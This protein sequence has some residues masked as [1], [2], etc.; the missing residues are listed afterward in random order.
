MYLYFQGVIFLHFCCWA[1]LYFQGVIFAHVCFYAVC[2]NVTATF[3]H[4]AIGWYFCTAARWC[5]GDIML[6][7]PSAC[8]VMHLM[9]WCWI[10]GVGCRLTFESEIWSC[11]CCWPSHGLL[12]IDK[13]TTAIDTFL[14]AVNGK[15]NKAIEWSTKTILVLDYVEMCLIGVY[16]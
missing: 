10:C 2:C 7:Q 5:N 3:L 1:F 13:S 15:C 11:F 12:S 6:T 8:G 14:S 16:A 4:A 9:Q